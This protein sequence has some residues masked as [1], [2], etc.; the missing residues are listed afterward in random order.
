MTLYCMIYLIPLINVRV[1]MANKNSHLSK[2]P[3]LI[4]K[5]SN[6]YLLR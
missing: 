3:N 5:N 6:I 2:N 4:T 1:P